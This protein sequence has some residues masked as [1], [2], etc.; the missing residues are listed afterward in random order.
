MRAVAAT[1]NT[2]VS[3]VLCH[4][5]DL[6]SDHDVEKL[7]ASFRSEYGTLDILV[8][9][10]AVISLGPIAT[11]AVNELDSQ[12]R[13]NV[14][15]AYVL[16][17]A[18]LPELRARKGQIVFI[19]SSLGMN[20]KANAAQYSATK[21]A[22]RAIADSLRDEVNPHGVRVLS[23]F[24]GRTAT[25]MQATVHE[26]E[27]RDYAPERLLQAEDVA[28]VVLRVLTLPCSA[29]VTDVSMRPLVKSY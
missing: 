24:L 19:N 22:L 29:E 13:T 23:V 8:H 1:A 25:P 14:R 6:S 17:Q 26:L 9:S 11:A 21:H 2:T 3:S 16:T 15:G 10:A 20:A 4:E 28:S 12:Y 7:L 27:G 5:A 18:L